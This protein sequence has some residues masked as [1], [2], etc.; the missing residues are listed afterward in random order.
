MARG[1]LIQEVIRDSNL[2][3]E[4]VAFAH[5]TTE[6]EGMEGELAL[7]HRDVEGLLY[8]FNDRDEGSLFTFDL[9]LRGSYAQPIEDGS[10]ED[11]V[12]DLVLRATHGDGLGGERYPAEGPRTCE[13]LDSD[14]RLRLLGFILSARSRA[15]DD[16]TEEKGCCPLL[17]IHTALLIMG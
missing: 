16:S 7:L 8:A 14:A 11:M 13:V 6:R 1:H 9:D 12:C 17:D 3:L 4:L 2:Q 15:E 10:L 5:D